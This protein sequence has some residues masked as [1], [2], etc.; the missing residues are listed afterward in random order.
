MVKKETQGV[1]SKLVGVMQASL[2]PKKQNEKGPM[3]CMWSQPMEDDD[4]DAAT[5]SQPL[6]SAG[7][8]SSITQMPSSSSQDAITQMPS[9]SSQDAIITDAII[10][11][12]T[13]AIITDATDATVLLSSGSVDDLLASLEQM[14]MV[15]TPHVEPTSAWATDEE[16]FTRWTRTKWWQHRQEVEAG[17]WINWEA[18]EMSSSAFQEWQ[19]NMGRWV[20][21]PANSWQDWGW[22][23]AA[24]SSSS[25][26]HQEATEDPVQQQG[27]WRGRWQDYLLTMPEDQAPPE[28]NPA[29]E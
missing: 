29:L 17:G 14:Q 7:S 4:D 20:D 19:R 24:A 3:I 13:D 21:Y 6:A 8:S 5:L 25:S 2:K 18:E 1:F 28:R 15:D 26:A 9:S 16:G 22:T 11:Y 23:S 27:R 10:T 12:A